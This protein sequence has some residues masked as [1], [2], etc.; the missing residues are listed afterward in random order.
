MSAPPSSGSGKSSWNLVDSD[1]LWQKLNWPSDITVLDLGCGEGRYSLPAADRVGP[2]GRVIAIDLWAEGID[3]LKAAAAQQ[4]INNIDARVADASGPLPLQDQSV[5]VCLMA[6]V[7]HDF[8]VAD[9]ADRALREV[10]RVLKP[11]GSMAVVEFKKEDSPYGPPRRIRLAV[12]DLAMMVQHLGFIRF[13]GVVDLG[14]DLYLS[15][16][17]RLAA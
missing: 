16:F 6:T 7:L 12:E 5:D 8:V 14:P 1:T 10:A 3:R 2:K 15:Q 9:M 13:S 11:Q 17:R 4:K